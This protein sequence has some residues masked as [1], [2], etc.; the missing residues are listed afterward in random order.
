MENV[1][2]KQQ[3]LKTHFAWLIQK[4]SLGEENNDFGEENN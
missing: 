2:R 3:T 1:Y 4:S